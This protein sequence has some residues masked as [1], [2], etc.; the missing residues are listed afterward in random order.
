[1]VAA[2]V[3][4]LRPWPFLDAL[5]A[6]RLAEPG[7]DGFY[8]SW[9][10]MLPEGEYQHPKFGQIDLSEKVLGELK[11]NFDAG[12]RGIEIALD[13]DHK[14]SE[15]DSAAPGWLEAVQVR[16]AQGDG[17]PAG[18]WGLVRWTTIGLRDVKSQIYRY[19]SAEFKPE[20]TDDLT[21]KKYKNV[22][23]GLTLT[24]RPFMK[25]MP[26]IALAESGNT[27][28]RA[29]GSVNKSSLPDSC[30]MDPKGRRLPI[31]EGA[32]P[33]V[34]GKY[35]KRGKL[36]LKGLAAALAA[37]HGAHTGK[38]MSGLPAGTV[39]R[40]ERLAAAHGIGGGSDDKD[41]GSSSAAASEAGWGGRGVMGQ[42]HGVTP[43]VT[44]EDLERS[45]AFA[46]GGDGNGNGKKVRGSK[47][48]TEGFDAL[49]DTHGAMTCAEHEHGK[50]GPHGHDGDADHSDAPLKDDGDGTDDGDQMDDGQNPDDTETYAD[51]GQNNGDDEPVRTSRRGGG[52]RTMS[53][54]DD[55]DDDG[56]L[57]LAEARRLREEVAE[58][59]RDKYRAQVDRWLTGWDAGAF[60]FVESRTKNP[61]AEGAKTKSRKVHVVLSRPARKAVEAYL[62]S[63]RAFTMAE[64]E[65]TDLL[66]LFETIA[67]GTVDLSVRG[68]S[69]DTDEAEEQKRVQSAAQARRKGI[70]Q[71][72]AL[73]TAAEQVALERGLAFS[74]LRAKSAKGDRTAY[75][76][77]FGETGVYPAA[78]KLIGY[79][80]IR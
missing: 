69:R 66:R 63:E 14:A 5:H 40:I 33:L 27:S 56:P 73:Q 32:G 45:L 47:G 61:D 12:T 80:G 43:G 38:P 24:N 51:G 25:N 46:D 78:A 29:W 26:A 77:L 67:A 16:P 3:T 4:R 79:E 60:Q 72:E 22:L 57:T 71:D 64:G 52:G 55:D 20:Y 53:E 74:E 10:M 19:L 15:G 13:Y 8:R 39:A 54:Y 9:V 1:M 30:F 50:Y 59:R 65:R 21:G 62:L 48:R 41:G 6:V 76:K 18:L 58:L 35:T 70:P 44:L 2:A 49:S 42:R 36:N 75:D 31:Y 23:I 37:V 28:S 17:A 34:N 11:R 68:S 7:S